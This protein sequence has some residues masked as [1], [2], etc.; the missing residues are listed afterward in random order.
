[1]SSTREFA[2]HWET[3]IRV[4]LSPLLG[5]RLAKTYRIL[6]TRYFEF[7]ELALRQD[8]VQ[9]ELTLILQCPWRIEESGQIVTG[10]EDARIEEEHLEGAPPTEDVEREGRTV[11]AHRLAAWLHMVGDEGE[12]PE[13]LDLRVVSIYTDE[14]GG[15]RLDLAGRYVLSV[16]PAGSVA[17]CWRLACPDWHFVV[18]PQRVYCI[19]EDIPPMFESATTADGEVLWSRLE[20]TGDGA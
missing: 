6:D 15:F 18:L 20:E 3:W 2:D 8:F 12:V 17:E 16:L 7:G 5:L 14:L 4:G 13:D 10:L 11:L 19:G 1:M 9:G